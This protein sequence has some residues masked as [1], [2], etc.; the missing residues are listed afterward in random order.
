M[1]IDGDDRS[2]EQF[3]WRVLELI[4]LRR[5]ALSKRSVTID[6]LTLAPRTAHLEVDVVHDVRFRGARPF[7]VRGDQA[8]HGRL[9]ESPFGLVEKARGC[10]G[11]GIAE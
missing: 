9:K 7:F 10:F 4:A 1:R 6:Q 11:T 2:T 8:F 5:G 3:R